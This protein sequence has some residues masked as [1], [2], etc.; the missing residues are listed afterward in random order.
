MH[1]IQMTIQKVLMLELK[2]HLRTFYLSALDTQTYIKEIGSQDYN[3]NLSIERASSVKNF[4]ISKGIETA[5]IDVYGKGESQEWL[6]NRLASGT[7][8]P[9]GRSY[10]RRVE[11]YLD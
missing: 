1:Y 10:N 8:N 9:I 3:M 7:D 6:P 11:I 2:F 4:L 5:K